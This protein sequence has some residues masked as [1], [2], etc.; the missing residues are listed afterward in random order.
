MTDT[1]TRSLTVACD[2]TTAFR[3]F[4][5]EIGTWWPTEQHSLHP[6]AVAVVEWPDRLGAH[7]PPDALRI[8]LEA[9]GEGRRAVIGGG[10][11]G[12]VAALADG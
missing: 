5:R 3:V 2:P 11:T 10:R 12:L 9:A 4:T 8:R 1:I 6:G 7:V